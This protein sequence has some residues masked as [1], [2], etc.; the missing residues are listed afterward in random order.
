VD[1][2]LLV[3]FVS[4][5]PLADIVQISQP[6]S[7]NAIRVPR[8]DHAGE[9]SVEPEV[10]VRFT[11]LDPSTPITQI[12]QLPVAND[13]YV[14]FDPSGDQSGDTSAAGS[15]VSLRGFDPSALITQMSQ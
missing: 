11:A 13:A 8:G 14:I 15:L 4:R 5:L 1:E 9:V 2:V 7:V 6:L 12:S 3:R 10:G